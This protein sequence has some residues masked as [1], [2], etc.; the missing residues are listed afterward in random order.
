MQGLKLPAQYLQG[1]RLCKSKWGGGEKIKTKYGF[2]LLINREQ[3]DEM[4]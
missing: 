2:V 4:T 1:Q 3:E